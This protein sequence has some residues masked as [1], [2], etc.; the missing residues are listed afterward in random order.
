MAMILGYFFSE[1]VF[2]YA[3]YLLISFFI[4]EIVVIATIREREKP[5]KD[6]EENLEEDDGE[7]HN[8]F[9]KVGTG[10]HN[11]HVKPVNFLGNIYENNYETFKEDMR[12]IGIDPDKKASGDE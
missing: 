5:T 3:P 11:A 2:R 8:D 4:I 1:L 6:I 9:S 10:D 12:N 7:Y